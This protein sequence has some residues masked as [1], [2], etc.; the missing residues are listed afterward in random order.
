MTLPDPDTMTNLDSC[1]LV[2]YDGVGNIQLPLLFSLD[3][4]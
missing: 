4:P 1:P 3:F 2:H